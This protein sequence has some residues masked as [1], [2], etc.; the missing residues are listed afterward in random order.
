MRHAK[1]WEYNV[2]P[3]NCSFFAL[4][5]LKKVASFGRPRRRWIPDVKETLNIPIDEVGDLARD[6]E[7]F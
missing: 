5:K 4:L 1:K 6:R 7:S 3:K 2:Y